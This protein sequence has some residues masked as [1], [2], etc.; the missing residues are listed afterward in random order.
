MRKS[1]A[2]SLSEDQG[3]TWKPTLCLEHEESGSFHY[4][5]VIQAKA[6]TYHVA[7]SYYVTGAQRIQHA[8]FS[9]CWVVS[10]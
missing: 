5:A 2:V 7:Y 8:A 10:R 1:L 3:R 6:G 9:E 4:P